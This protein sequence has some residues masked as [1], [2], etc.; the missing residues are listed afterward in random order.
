MNMRNCFT[1]LVPI[2]FAFGLLASCEPVP[3]KPATTDSADG[4]PIRYE[5]AGSGD[6]AIVFV[7][8][9]T[10]DRSFWDEQFE[11]FAKRYQVVRL[12]LAGHGD[13]GMER[14]QY[15]M[16]S[17]ADDVVA[18][19]NTLKL[20]R[21][22]LVGHSMGGPVIIEAAK[23]L[24]DRVM[25][26]VG[27]DTFYTPF[28]FPKDEAGI[29]AFVKPFEEDFVNASSGLVQNMFP[30]GTDPVLVERVVNII[31][32]ADKDMAVQAMRDLFVWSAR[33]RP[34]VLDALGTKLRN[35]NAGG[36]GTRLHN[37]VVLIPGVGHF[38]QM[39]KPEVFNTELQTI[40]KE[41]G[42]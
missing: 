41:F 28:T 4:T 7:H 19:A 35:I 27:V 11:Y 15:N 32:R 16:V 5:V 23:Q 10:C 36:D 13:S 17:F 31:S 3:Q 18:V 42:A 26:V 1:H 8:C 6:T 29:N 39:E 2:I 33:E 12:D 30:P 25:G 40:L 37:S 22:V 20:Q 34:A 38:V 24:G 21:I 9:W 14:K